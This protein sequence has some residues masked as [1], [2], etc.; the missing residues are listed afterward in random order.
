M[1]K[2]VDNK[3][4][5]EQTV[6]TNILYSFGKYNYTLNSQKESSFY[7]EMFT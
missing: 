2:E 4:E 3:S 7:L 6:F 5:S 1:Q